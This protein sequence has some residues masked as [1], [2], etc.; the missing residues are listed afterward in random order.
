[1][2]KLQVYL[3]CSIS[4]LIGFISIDIFKNVVLAYSNYNSEVVFKDTILKQYTSTSQS[5]IL[6]TYSGKGYD[7]NIEKIDDIIDT[8]DTNTY[9]YVAYKNGGLNANTNETI[10]I[11]YWSKTI[12]EPISLSIHNTGYSNNYGAIG[13]AYFY[14][15]NSS[16]TYWDNDTNGVYK[17]TY[18]FKTDSYALDSRTSNT[19]YALIE[20]SSYFCY[21]SAKD[22]Y[23]A[24]N[25]SG[26]IGNYRNGILIFST[27]AN[28]KFNYLYNK[29]WASSSK[30]GS[31]TN[32][33]LLN[34]E[35]SETAKLEYGDLLFG[36]NYDIV[37]WSSRNPTLSFSTTNNYD[38][39]N[40]LIS[41]NLTLTIDN[42]NSDYMYQ[43]QKGG[44]SGTWTTLDIDEISSEVYG[45]YWN[46]WTENTNI[47]FRVI[48]PSTSELITSAT[49]QV[50]D[51]HSGYITID[52]SDYSTLNDINNANKSS[53]LGLVLIPK[54]TSN[55]YSSTIFFSVPDYYLNLYN[56]NNNIRFKFSNKSMQLSNVEYFN[57]LDLL[58]QTAWEQEFTP[59]Y[60][61]AETI[62]P[63][64]YNISYFEGLQPTLLN[65]EVK[66]LTI[67]FDSE[68]YNYSIIDSSNDNLTIVD[69]NTN[70][71]IDLNNL[72]NTDK[73][74]INS[75]TNSIKSFLNEMKTY[76]T[77]PYDLL[78]Y[79]LSSLN[80]ST[81]MTII[82]IFVL[83]VILAIIKII[84][85]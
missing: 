63:N 12:T 14:M 57:S 2:K 4:I 70:E 56:E 64:N 3:I 32:I 79:F 55:S 75:Y 15:N 19:K 38:S 77:I 8:I 48:N 45:F 26:T 51:I 23:R 67:T 61:I 59:G 82:T 34:N 21:N 9:Y 47:Y 80:S 41:I 43:F 5:E 60:F 85:R 29:N 81:L 24:C 7:D 11:A 69:P 76:I 65:I 25:S 33:V 50:S 31:F 37:Y 16:T 44:T 13:Q 36:N 62:A 72:N 73:R 52:I 46:N 27:N 40:N 1:M 28:F 84:R 18:N 68:V 30:Y 78:T 42:Y 53:K 54:A 20:G 49:Y 6:S 10:T 58:N 71:T 74:T 22:F 35:T 66:P 17:I 83:L 39:F